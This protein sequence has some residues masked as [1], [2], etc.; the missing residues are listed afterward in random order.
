MHISESASA[1][2]LATNYQGSPLDVWYP[3]PALGT[4]PTDVAHLDAAITHDELRG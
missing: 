1:L 2:G 3:A 4:S